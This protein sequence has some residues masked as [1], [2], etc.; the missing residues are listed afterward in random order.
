MWDAVLEPGFYAPLESEKDLTAKLT[1]L[2]DS[3]HDYQDVL[4]IVR[5]FVAEHKF[6][7]GVQLLESL[8]SVEENG[9][10]LTRL[11][12]VTLKCLIPRVEEE[13]RIKHGQFIGG[14]LAVIAMGKYG[15]WELTHTSD[16][17]IIFLYHVDDMDSVSDG[18]KP[19]G[20]SQ[21]FSRLG[22]HVITAITALT[23][24]GRLYEV[25]TRLRP[26]GSQGPLVVTL[27]TFADYYCASAWTWEHMALTRARVVIAPPSAAKALT[28][29][30]REILTTPR[31]G[32]NL[33]L[34]VSDMRGK[35]FAEFGSTNPWAIK[36]VR[37]GL[38]DMEFICQYL[39]LRDGA[40]TDGLF[41]PH[42]DESINRLGAAGALSPEQAEVLLDAHDFLQRVQSILRLCL[43][44]HPQGDEDIPQGLRLTLCQATA[45]DSF[46]ELKAL[47][48]GKQS[49]V[50]SLFQDV[51]ETPA[52][53]L[54]ET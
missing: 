33:L 44:G 41:H 23:P 6:R 28:G 35:L 9:K 21:Y 27:K 10:A 32:D 13:F 2:L 7:A 26:S 3:V 19:L 30:I 4:D 20:P 22:Q 48:I 1:M 18:D 51:I 43:G 54:A 8:A 47:V 40:R 16:L 15:G 31:D 38:V 5:R 42:L 52:N 29:T 50:Y 34:A 46:D 37:G 49:A 17:D 24:E 53:T 36:H 45:T 25:D 11:A 12:D 14:G 39:M